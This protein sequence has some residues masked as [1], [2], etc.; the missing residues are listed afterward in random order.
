M[1]DLSDLYRRT[2]D[3]EC[4]IVKQH[5]SADRRSDCRSNEADRIRDHGEV[6]PAL[7]NDG[8][9][10]RGYQLPN[11]DGNPGEYRRGPV[12]KHCRQ[13]RR[14]PA[15]VVR[16]E[17]RDGDDGAHGIAYHLAELLANRPR[18]LERLGAGRDIAREAFD[19]GGVESRH[20][21]VA[22]CRQRIARDLRLRDD[23]LV[24]HGTV[25]ERL[26]HELF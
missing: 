11:R 15:Q 2:A 13:C 5:Q 24:H 10:Q 22:K 17:L 20:Q 7:R 1:H 23:L 8:G 4:R 18:F 9:L 12:R 3:L 21:H 14:D 19:D 25:I 26:L 16:H 6:K